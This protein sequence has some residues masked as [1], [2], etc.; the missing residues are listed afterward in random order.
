[1]KHERGGSAIRAWTIAVSVVYSTV[2]AAGGGCVFY[3]SIRPV[4]I[5]TGYIAEFADFPWEAANLL[6]AAVLVV[7]PV[8][9]LALGTIYVCMPI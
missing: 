2:L 7:G 1:V 8:M 4:S 9:L 3:A 5:P 6:L